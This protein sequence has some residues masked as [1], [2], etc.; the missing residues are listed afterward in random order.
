MTQ[1]P[2]PFR[3]LMAEDT[4][5]VAKVIRATLQGL[6]HTVVGHAENGREALA[7][8]HSLKPDIVVMDIEMPEMDGLEATRL[9]QEQC[10]CPVV[11]LTSRVQPELVARA[12]VVG[13]GA[14]L[15]KPPK[16]DELERAM[17]IASARFADLVALRRLNGELQTALDEIKTL[18][19]LLPICAHC[20]KIRDDEGAWSQVEVYVQAHTEAQFTH[21]ICPDCVRKYFPEVAERVLNR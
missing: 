9:I 3:I 5:L 4:A 8:A 17:A 19:G 1:T 7:M 6:G 13:A 14:Y 15:V 11:L 18:R 10:P 16:A 12:S 21:G 20:K 2:H